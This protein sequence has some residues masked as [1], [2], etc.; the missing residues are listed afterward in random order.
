MNAE[1]RRFYEAL[2]YTAVTE[3]NGEVVGLRHFIYTTGLCCGLDDSGYAR[4][5]CYGGYQEALSALADWKT[6][7]TLAAAARSVRRSTIPARS[8]AIPTM[9]MARP[10]PSASLP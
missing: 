9:P 4:R 8:R 6:S 10:A 3:V 5:Y 7:A 2:G 1:R